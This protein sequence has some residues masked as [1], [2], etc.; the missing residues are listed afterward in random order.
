MKTVDLTNFIKKLFGIAQKQYAYLDAC[1]KC[2][3][4]FLG[5]TE[6]QVQQ[7]LEKHLRMKHGEKA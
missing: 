6:K 7:Y 3:K 4:V 5:N 1:P 2:G